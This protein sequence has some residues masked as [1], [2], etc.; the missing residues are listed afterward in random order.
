M[1]AHRQR[2]TWAARQA[3]APAAI[4]GYGVED[5][6]HPAHQP[7]PS[8]EDYAKGDPSAW[9]EDPH[10]A[11]Y[12][13]SGPPALPGYGVEDQDH[14]AHG[15]QVGRQAGLKEAVRR[16]AAKCLVIARHTLGKT[17]STASIEERAFGL[18]DLS[19]A[20]IE[21]ALQRI[22]GQRKQAGGFFA[23]DLDLMGEEDDLFSEDMDDDL[24]G[25]DDEGDLFSEDLLGCGDDMYGEEDDEALLA[26]FARLERKVARLRRQA[27]QNDPDGETL[28]PDA[29]SE[30]EEK[31]EEAKANKA[32]SVSK[33]AAWFAISDGDRDGFVTAREWRGSRKAFLAMDKDRDGILSFSDIRLAADEE[34]DDEEEETASKKAYGHF[35]D[36]D[37]EEMDMLSA[38]G[39]D[40]SACG[41]PMGSIYASKKS[42]D[43]DDADADEGDADEGDED[44]DSDEDAS[45]EASFFAGHG[46]P[47]GLSEESVLTAADEAAFANVF[48]RNAS[49]DEDEDEDEEVASKKASK[50]SEDEEADEDEEEEVAS[51]KA[52]RTA[53]RRPQPRKKAAG[54]RTLGSLSGGG[55]TKG[56]EVDELSKLWAS[57]PDVS[58]AF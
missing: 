44:E 57:A 16:R 10:P 21:S 23:D 15:G 50:K 38:M 25:F 20:K 19:D 9:A 5:Q 24:L 2:M 13:D 37:D 35:S 42:E 39:D 14:P 32:A 30:D 22:A 31:G 11:P 29:K 3:A 52:S 12:G 47:M 55:S 58:D 53:S 7:D 56:S 17:A 1:S 54:V 6:D 34:A 51:K 43:E 41:E 27:D 8:H 48:G 18:M 4:P 45:K 26:R 33:E 28:T 36:L 46:D 40:I 49:D